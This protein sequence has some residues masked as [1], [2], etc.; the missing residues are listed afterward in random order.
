MLSFYPTNLDPWRKYFIFELQLEFL[1]R[2]ECAETEDAIEGEISTEILIQE[3]LK[4]DDF[5]GVIVL[6]V[7]E[8]FG[9]VQRA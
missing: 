6:T 8:I 1:Y 2:I 4:L 9:N 5:I 7:F 3:S